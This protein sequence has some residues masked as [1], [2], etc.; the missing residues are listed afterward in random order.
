MA[1]LDQ[2]IKAWDEGQW[3]FS[4]AFEGLADEDVWRRPHPQLLSIG[5]LAGHIAFWDA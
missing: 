2:L 1:K 4:L 5:E 3:E